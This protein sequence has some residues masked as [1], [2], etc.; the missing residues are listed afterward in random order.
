MS[1]ICLIEALE[2]KELELRR[3]HIRRYDDQEFLKN[4]SEI[5]ASLNLKLYY[6]IFNFIS[7]SH[8]TRQLIFFNILFFWFYLQ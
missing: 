4:K 3:S 1:I 5:Q 6:N 8:L 7:Y 2:K